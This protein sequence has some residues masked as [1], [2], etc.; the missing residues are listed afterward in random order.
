M[1]ASEFPSGAS[2][3]AES[4]DSEE[5]A[6]PV[7]AAPVVREDLLTYMETYARLEPERQVSVYARTTG[8]VDR[9]RLEEGDRV[10]RGQVLVELEREEASLLLRAS[11]ADHAEAVWRWGF[12]LSTSRSTTT[13]CSGC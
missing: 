2:D 7:R 9:L 1:S 12:P 6:I 10:S 4:Y 11:R 5:A 13:D 3:A 8:L